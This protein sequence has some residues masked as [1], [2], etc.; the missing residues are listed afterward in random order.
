MWLSYSQIKIL[1]SVVLTAQASVL[2]SPLPSPSVKASPIA[3]AKP[4][5][6]E[7]FLSRAQKD[8][9]IEKWKSAISHYKTYFKKFPAHAQFLEARYSYGKAL[10]KNR[11]WKAAKKEFEA[12]IDKHPM[13]Q[14]TLEARL[15]LAQ[16]NIELRKWSEAVLL[17]Q[18]VL[19]QPMADHAL[20]SQAHWI[21]ARAHFENH[22]PL[23]A[24]KA[25]D[26]FFSESPGKTLDA[27][28]SA[29]LHRIQLRMKLADC[30]RKKLPRVLPE[31]DWISQLQ[32]QALC[33]FE[34][35]N[36]VKS[37]AKMEEK[38]V[39]TQSIREWN[40]TYDSFMTQAKKIP[41]PKARMSKKQIKQHQIE[42]KLFFDR[43]AS[44][45]KTQV[46]QVLE[47]W[48]VELPPSI[49]PLLLKWK[50]HL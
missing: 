45:L 38:T 29:E 26:L 3:I 41:L 31:Q 12:F 11:E 2:P 46:S 33:L 42:M 24:E 19:D 16:V 18:E 43:E 39:L 14:D 10:M 9:S 21:Q 44:K 1:T 13:N 36:I 35:L 30:K 20:R 6:A 27:K 17:A 28:T 25:A 8:M 15:A 32:N 23:E 37:I 7:D 49:Q 5:T 4:K 48:L 34:S 50:D 47:A 22:N 40:L